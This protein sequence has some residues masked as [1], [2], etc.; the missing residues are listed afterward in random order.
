MQRIAG[1]VLLLFYPALVAGVLLAPRCG[2][3]AAM[4]LSVAR[5]GTFTVATW[6]KSGI[7][8]KAI[9]LWQRDLA[10]HGR[11]DTE[12]FLVSWAHALSSGADAIA[13]VTTNGIS[14]QLVVLDVESGRSLASVTSP[15]KR[16]PMRIVFVGSGARTVV[17]ADGDHAYISQASNG[18]TDRLE[19]DEGY[20]RSAPNNQFVTISTL[21]PSG[22]GEFGEQLFGRS[23][24]FY[25]AVPAGLALLRTER[26][27]TDDWGGMGTAI[28]P[29]GT[30]AIQ[31]Q[32]HVSLTSLSGGENR[33]SWPKERGRVFRFD[34]TGDY[35]VFLGADTESIL[36]V[37]RATAKVLGRYDM[38]EG[39]YCRDCQFQGT[40]HILILENRQD[41][42]VSDRIIQWNWRT[43]ETVA[44]SVGG[45]DA[46]TLRPWSI[47]H[48]CLVGLWIILAMP[49][50]A[51]S[52]RLLVPTS[53]LVGL[54]AC[55]FIWAYR[56]PDYAY[57]YVWGEENLP[58]L[59]CVVGWLTVACF[60]SLLSLV[61]R[62]NIVRWFSAILVVQAIAACFLGHLNAA[63]GW[64]FPIAVFSTCWLLLT[65]RL[66]RGVLRAW[67]LRKPTAD[68]SDR[69]VRTF[70]FRLIDLVALVAASAIAMA[71]GVKIDSSGQSLES[72]GWA[73]AFGCAIAVAASAAA[74]AAVG[75]FWW[76][77]R[78]P[79]AILVVGLLA[80]GLSSFRFVDAGKPHGLMAG[81]LL[82]VMTS[83]IGVMVW[84]GTM[85]F[86]GVYRARIQ[87]RNKRKMVIPES[88]DCGTGIHGRPATIT[89]QS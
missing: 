3:R 31:H 21:Y 70:S 60:A 42:D 51:P 39:S 64:F 54:A 53:V 12:G 28:G 65:F 67:L 71:L 2:P 88:Q 46:A 76:W 23:C 36:V 61:L 81:P 57:F 10:D 14:E 80:W 62:E 56:H 5:D 4:E 40:D 19:A 7:N 24:R 75:R 20:P 52:N 47:L 89:S 86:R 68:A 34:P 78:Y 79:V 73:A 69:S 55:G 83:G 49:V 44:K 15:A 87:P 30:I 72:A 27:S 66:V 74:W 37:D 48:S 26:R 82:G 41:E 1:H 85:L 25:Q 33:I 6:Q 63:S 22:Q 18:K 59:I 43:G 17:V 50:A 38:Q 13:T 29:A 32:D 9:D 77:A 84:Y 8:D 58:W 45:L 35:L 11:L 16:M